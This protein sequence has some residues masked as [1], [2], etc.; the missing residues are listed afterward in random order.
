MI[1]LSKNDVVDAVF[2]RYVDSYRCTVD[3]LDFMPERDIDSFFAFL[4]KN[5]LKDFKR[6]NKEAR[7]LKRE[8]V[9]EIKRMTKRNAVKEFVQTLAAPEEPA[10]PEPESETLPQPVPNTAPAP[11]EEQS[12]E[13]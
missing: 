9:R 8:K 3:L 7:K 5:M 4:R 12:H 1:D 11:I 13:Q 10:E 2:N 6:V